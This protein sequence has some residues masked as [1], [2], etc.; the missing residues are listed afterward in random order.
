MVVFGLASVMD[1]CVGVA[2]RSEFA[3]YDV[4]EPTLCMVLFAACDGVGQTLGGV[5]AG[6]ALALSG[7]SAI[8][9]FVAMLGIL[10]VSLPIVS[11]RLK[12]TEGPTLAPAAA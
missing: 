2:M 12:R 8:G 7:Y 10:A 4:G 1:A 6:M 5:L 3:S 11:V 9:L